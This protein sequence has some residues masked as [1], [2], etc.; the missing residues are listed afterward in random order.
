MQKFT[1]EQLLVTKQI[2]EL[3][4]TIAYNIIAGTLPNHKNITY[5]LGNPSFS[6]LTN[7]IIFG[8]TSEEYC[9]G[10]TERGYHES[11]VIKLED[12]NDSEGAIQRAIDEHNKQKQAAIEA[13]ARQKTLERQAMIDRE[14]S[15]AK[16]TLEKLNIEVTPDIMAKMIETATKRVD[17]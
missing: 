4:E 1:A 17:K 9:C 15:M 2:M 13:A 14:V 3:A 5:E 12:L 7:D 11:I 10:Q 8:L 6:V 16:N